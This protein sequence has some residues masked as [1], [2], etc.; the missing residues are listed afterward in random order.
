MK[1]TLI[2]ILLIKFCVYDSYTQNLI[3]NYSFEDTTTRVTP[4]FLPADW[5]A[6]TLEGW[7]YY[8][9]LQNQTYPDWGTPDNGNGYQQAKTGSAYAGINLYNLWTFQRNPRR[10]YMQ[11][12]LERTLEFDSTYCFQLYI[13]LADSIHFASKNMLGVYFSAN[14]VSGNHRHHLPY[15]P[16]LVVSP[17]T[18][19]TDRVNWVKID[20]QYKATGGEEYITIGNFNDTNYIDTAF[21]PGGGTQTWMEASYYY[22]DDVWLSHCDSIPDS[23]TGLNERSLKHALSVYPNPFVREITVE[24]KQHKKLDFVL[25]NSLGQAVA[26]KVQKQNKKYT[27]STPQ[28]PKGLYW[29]RVSDG[30][31]EET[32]KLIKE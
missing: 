7:N 22:I 20:L 31:Q 14:A 19:I 32:F 6:A 18:Y 23:L 28:L 30:K 26:V 24:T 11:V 9:P 13:S 8:T 15:T 27:I 12:Q 4:L 1:R 10:E 21:V 29:L 17:N 25:Y 5:E 2:L 16:Q 3:P